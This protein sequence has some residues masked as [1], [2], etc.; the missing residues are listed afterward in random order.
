MTLW[1]VLQGSR[2]NSKYNFKKQIQIKSCIEALRCAC[3]FG[4]L[5]FSASVHVHRNI[6]KAFNYLKDYKKYFCHILLYLNYSTFLSI[7]YEANENKIIIGLLTIKEIKWQY[8]TILWVLCS[9]TLFVCYCAS[10]LIKKY[11]QEIENDLN[12]KC[13]QFNLTQNIQNANVNC[14]SL[15]PV[16]I[17][18]A[19]SAYN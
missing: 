8:L 2:Y 6:T 12:I 9:G 10:N 19:Y 4:K 5:Y 1:A 3:A 18:T 11:S 7:I 13:R 15:L 16:V 14:T 17:T